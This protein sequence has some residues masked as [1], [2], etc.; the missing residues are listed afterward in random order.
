MSILVRVVR[1]FREVSEVVTL[2][3]TLILPDTPTMGT[4]LDLRTEGIEDA[5]TVVGMTPRSIPDG[6]G[7]RP[8]SV[9]VLL[10]WEPLPHAKLA[11]EAG[12]SDPAPVEHP[13]VT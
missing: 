11:R 5:L 9:K 10:F 2:E 1:Q 12:W 13:T 3:K 7:A 6:P 8:P 4:R